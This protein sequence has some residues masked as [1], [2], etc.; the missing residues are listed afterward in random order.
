MTLQFATDGMRFSPQMLLDY[1]TR[2]LGIQIEDIGVAPTVLVTWS[3]RVRESLTRS[4]NGEILANAPF[5]HAFSGHIASAP[6]TI[7]QCPI[8]AP[9]TIIQME[10]LIV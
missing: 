10:E 2:R 5:R 3:T 8:G 1:H 6:V 4:V 7:V 9:G